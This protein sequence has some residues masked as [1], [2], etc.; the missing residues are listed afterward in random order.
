MKTGD[1]SGGE[2]IFPEYDICVNIEQG[3]L[4]MFNPHIAHC[5]NPIDGN[6]RISFVL[7]LREKMAEC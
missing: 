1:Y 3:D 6:G 2:L 4:L 7:Y 5:N